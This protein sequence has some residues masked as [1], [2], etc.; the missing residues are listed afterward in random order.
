MKYANRDE[1]V[2]AEA[3][4]IF[5][6]TDRAIK[7]VAAAITDEATNLLDIEGDTPT[8]A[9]AAT[10]LVLRDCY[11]VVHGYDAHDRERIMASLQTLT[12]YSLEIVEKA[13]NDAA[14]KEVGE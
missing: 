3:G 5:A 12:K 4:Q 13:V 6:D 2:D 10:L 7:V 14:E 11:R 9:M 1:A 8:D